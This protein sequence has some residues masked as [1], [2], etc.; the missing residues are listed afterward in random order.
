MTTEV[1]IPYWVLVATAA[2]GRRLPT[3]RY[4][5]LHP[6]SQRFAASPGYPFERGGAG[7]HAR[8]TTPPDLSPLLPFWHCWR[9]L[10][11]VL[12]QHRRRTRLS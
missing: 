8:E 4:V 10:A 5:F 3:L 2:G 6:D 9:R 11:R 12:A 1:P 7:A